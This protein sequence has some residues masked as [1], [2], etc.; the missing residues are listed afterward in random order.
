M[1]TLIGFA[2]SLLLIAGCSPGSNDDTSSYGS[3]RPGAAQED[4]SGTDRSPAGTPSENNVP[5]SDT[6]PSTPPSTTPSDSTEP[7]TTPSPR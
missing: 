1:R 6:T 3:G 4:S 2:A 7:T 5:P